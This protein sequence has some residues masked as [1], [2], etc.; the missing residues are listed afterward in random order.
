MMPP[1]EEQSFELEWAV[2]NKWVVQVNPDANDINRFENTID[3]TVTYH[4][5]FGR[6]AGA[7][8]AAF[9][10]AVNTATEPIIASASGNETRTA[11]TVFG[12]AELLF[13]RAASATM[14][15]V[16]PLVEPRLRLKLHP[17][18]LDDIVLLKRHNGATK[19]PAVA[20][21]GDDSLKHVLER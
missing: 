10:G 8:D 13:G 6:D 16:S 19:W 3:I 18:A 20:E 21:T 7:A 11:A 12:P 5:P 17:R 4:L 1:T 2:N 15:A 14:P 9:V